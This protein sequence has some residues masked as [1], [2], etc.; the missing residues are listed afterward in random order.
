MNIAILELKILIISHNHEKHMNHIKI[1]EY[2]VQ[3]QGL[4]GKVISLP[5][6][7]LDDHKVKPGDSIEFFRAILDNQDCLILK[8]KKSTIESI[9]PSAHLQVSA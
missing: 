5:A 9:Q 4:R 3:L 8:V 6:V 7:W 2:K 1:K